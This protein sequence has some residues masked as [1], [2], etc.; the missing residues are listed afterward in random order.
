MKKEIKLV[1]GMAVLLAV[2]VNV[3][4]QSTPNNALFEAAKSGTVEDV[5]AA[6]NAGAS[7]K[8]KDK[9]GYTALFLAVSQNSNPDVIKALLDAGS[10]I[11][12]KV[13]YGFT[14]LTQTAANNKSPAAPS[15]I[16]ILVDAGADVNGTDESKNTPLIWACLG[17]NKDNVDVIKILIDLGAD[18]NAKNNNG[19]TALKCAAGLTET[20]A[21]IRALIDAGADK[22]VRDR[23]GKRPID[24]LES[25]YDRREFSKTDAYKEIRDLLY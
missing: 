15:I 16:K 9:S 1:T 17:G 14:V 25:R 22:N 20:P 8:A 23:D 2:S 21:V 18:V 6:L 11:N 12:A 4:A 24:S 5:K 19:L 3:F 13:R 7:V 10:D